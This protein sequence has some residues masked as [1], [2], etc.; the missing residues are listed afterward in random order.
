MR[1]VT[2]GGLPAAAAKPVARRRGA[3]PGTA[4]PAKPK[5]VPSPG[6]PQLAQRRLS[7]SSLQDYARCSYRFYL[8][9]VLGLPRV[10]APPPD[11]AGEP[12][13]APSPLEGRLRGTLVHELLERLDF[14][15]P[16]PPGAE[17]VLALGA[18]HGLE[19]APDHVEDIREQVAAFARSPLCARLA[20]A[21]GVRR[22]AGF[23][24]ELSAGGGGPLVTGVVDVLARE[25]DG[26]VL[27]VDYKTDR[28]GDDETPAALV[29]RAYTTQR[30]VYAL[31]ALHAGAP[32]VEVAYCLLERPAEPVAATFGSEDSAELTDAL[33][34]LAEGVLAERW[35]VAAEPHRELCGDCPGREALCSWPEAMT[36]RPPADVYEASAGTLAG[37]GGP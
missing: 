27:I 24:F 9:R 8:S 10:P 28:L 16:Q 36:L 19:L 21:G 23:A 14:G 1:L 3:G 32:R 33:L 30:R 34:R 20:D 17:Q 26:S 2:A 5:V 7:Y 25:R 37:S 22:E 29:E 31:A 18:S 11:D 35:P 4:L 13:A 6:R 12:P 15:R